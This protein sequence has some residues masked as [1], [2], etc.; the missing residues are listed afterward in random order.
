MRF[1][2]AAAADA[3]N[4]IMATICG[5]FLTF[6]PFH[7]I[8]F[9]ANYKAWHQDFPLHGAFVRIE[10]RIT[11]EYP[12]CVLRLRSTAFKRKAKKTPNQITIT[13]SV[14]VFIIASQCH[15]QANRTQTRHSIR[16]MKEELTVVRCDNVFR[17]AAIN[18]T[19]FC[20]HAQKR[21]SF[22]LHLQEQPEQ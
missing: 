13:L 9:S 10:R 22:T 19:C 15:R 6:S 2:C 4:T 20:V 11:G 3:C 21:N 5:F 8:K 1:I 17:A 18:F 12:L 16:I 7:Y 14:S